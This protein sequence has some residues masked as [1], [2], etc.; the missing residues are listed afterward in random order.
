MNQ[1]DPGT[2][3]T[4]AMAGLKMLGNTPRW[5]YFAIFTISGFSGLIYESIWSHYLKLFLGHAAYAQSLVLIIFMG[6]M[7]TGSWLAAR[8]TERWRNPV[9]Y[10]AI[11]EAI[12]G[13][14]ALVFHTTF[15]RM[16]DTFYLSI[17]PVLGNATLGN[18]L[19]WT[20]AAALIMPQSVLLGMTFPLLTAGI[21]RRYPDH[22]GGSLAM[23]YF[24]NSIGAAA[25]VLASGFWLISHVG[26][27]G[28]IMT[29]GLLNIS[30]ALV[31]WILV[32]ADRHP[33]KT[34][35]AAVPTRTAHQGDSLAGLFFFAAGVTGA[36]SFIYE[37]GWIRMLSLVLGATTHSFELMLSAF[38]TG[39]ALGGLWMKWRIDRLQDPLHYAGWVQVLMGMLAIFTIPVYV[40]TFDWIA[41][42]L[43]GL[44]NTD[45]GY[46]LY[47]VFSHGI[48]LLVMVPTTFLAGM[49]LPLFTHILMR[50]HQGE[51]CIGRVY[52]AN[53]LG[54]IA[55]VLF[56]I[57]IGMPLLGL[58]L[59]IGSGA[60]LD[61][62]LGL[63]L[64]Y[65]SRSP[66]HRLTPVVTAAL[67]SSLILLF[68]VTTVQIDPR[69]LA[70]GVF[71]YRW[72]QL[73][74]SS[75][76]LSYK[77]GKTASVSL[78]AQGTRYTIATNG[79]PDATIEMDPGATRSDD[80]ITM[81]MAAALPLAYNPEAKAVANIGMGSGLTT[82]TF[83]ADDRIRLVDTI[84]I[85]SAMVQTAMGF[86]ERVQR[87]FND[88]R[89][90]IHIEDAKSF[91][92]LQQNTYD[93]IVAE[94]SNPWV[95]G[96]ASLFSAEFYRT[97]PRYLKPDGVFVQ[98]LQL[99][100]FNDQLVHSVLKALTGTFADVAIYNTDN[101]DILIVA[102][103]H[104]PLGTPDFNR[105]LGGTLGTELARVGLKTPSDFM[106]RKSGTQSIIDAI[107]AQ[108]PVP[109][110]SD[111]FPYLDLNAGRARFRIEAATMFYNWGVTPLPVLEMLGMEPF[112]YAKVSAV[113]AFSRTRIIEQADSLYRAFT[114][115]PEQ[116]LS[117]S[118][119]PSIV[120]A[121]LLSRSCE[122]IKHE[123]VWLY[124]MH[125]LAEATLP[126]MTAT[127]ASKLLETAL[128]GTCMVQGSERSRTWMDLY[129]SVAARDPE[130]MAVTGDI[131]LRDTKS[132][133]NSLAYAL[134]AVMLGQLDSNHPELVLQA[135]RERP[136]PLQ[137][138]D[139]KPEQELI[140]R[141]AQ[142]RLAMNTTS[143]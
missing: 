135:W 105:V 66:G 134:T 97:L 82:H 46:A 129:Q 12:I 91:F 62:L 119:R 24:T 19:K 20:S 102:K 54:S 83:L 17:L 107:L 126:F 90:R 35:A 32:K 127:A 116:Q 57:H 103:A 133:T 76:V 7:A 137:H 106:V 132:D 72:A 141:V 117:A 29:A 48:A 61:V 1:S 138:L 123:D 130:R 99:Y 115:A 70:S 27:P 14:L 131:A 101:T 80:E 95:S 111:Y 92:S 3:L 73:D 118:I 74:D 5:V 45:T 112:D 65:R 58:K 28:T 13:L 31:V 85:E 67:V 125:T 89:S 88:P 36:A 15:V 34:A 81:T 69:R 25:G 60:L 84:E 98:W 55:G 22:P 50:A 68:I 79:K 77:D 64:L 109:T 121:K 140:L 23:L 108:S 120:V 139:A 87:A 75:R 21:L 49:T 47:T 136:D 18:A 94:P 124:G 128:P 78:I 2:P 110:N 114:V 104:G 51:G 53:T 30:I 26:L 42:L 63:L 96:V 56:A 122:P 44:Q 40:R 86:G 143:H 59:L 38:I 4:D 41:S 39:L 10:Y 37:I 142:L 93:I 16:T 8:F 113:N 43:S 52:A 100:E 6:G 11:V 9:L 33:A 71:R